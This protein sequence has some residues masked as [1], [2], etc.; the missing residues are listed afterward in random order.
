MNGGVYGSFAVCEATFCVRFEW[1]GEAA[2]SSNLRHN[3]INQAGRFEAAAG[4]R[5]IR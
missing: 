5:S 2:Q 4:N 3:G 1:L